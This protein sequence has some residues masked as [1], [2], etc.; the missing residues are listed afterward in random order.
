MFDVFR[1]PVPTVH[2]G[3]VFV[4]NNASVVVV[5]ARNFLVKPEFGTLVDTKLTVNAAA[6]FLNSLAVMSM[7]YAGANSLVSDVLT[8]ASYHDYTHAGLA[9]AAVLQLLPTQNVTLLGVDAPK[10]EGTGTRVLIVQNL[11]AGYTITLG[12]ANTQSSEG[13]RFT[14]AGNTSVVIPGSGSV[15]LVW[16]TET[17]DWRVLGGAGGSST[18]DANNALFLNGQPGSYYTNASNISTG[19]L[20]AA[21]L[22]GT[23]AINVSGTAYGKAEAAL[24]VNNAVSAT[25]ALTANNATYAY[26]KAESQLNVN[27]AN[28][29]HSAGVFRFVDSRATNPAPNAFSMGV[30]WDFKQNAT[31]ALTDGGSFTA[32][33][34]ISKWVDGTGGKRNQF[35]LTDN[36]NMWTRVSSADLTTWGDWRL[37]YDSGNTPTQ[38]VVVG[39]LSTTGNIA[40]S[41]AFSAASLALSTQPHCHVYRSG[42][43]GLTP[44]NNTTV[45]VDWDL[46]GADTTGTM[47][48]NS[49]NNSRITVPSD[50]Y[51][52]VV[53]Q[54]VWDTCATGIRKSFVRINGSAERL[55]QEIGPGP[56]VTHILSGVLWI[57]AGQYVEACVYQTSGAALSTAWGYSDPYNS[58]L[59]VTKLF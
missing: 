42:G 52:L 20:A 4:S 1:V 7:H 49:T 22:S 44:A 13:N 58:F 35:A 2:N 34:T 14:L 55:K 50:G 29:A 10:L 25:S 3:D 32:L 45:A 54:N 5:S 24:N 47:H 59:S 36:G 38:N 11:A 12:H 27:N 15:Q 56:V 6:K 43:T 31:I 16:S 26:G 18:G 17:K 51:Y 57:S 46:E 37:V 23:Y 33:Q 21:R 48:N 19:T 39:N 30:Q 40:A 9:Q 41:G 53:F 8:Q 28:T